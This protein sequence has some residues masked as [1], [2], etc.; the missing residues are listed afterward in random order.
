M[1]FVD[2]FGDM[3]QGLGRYA[4]TEQTGAT[5][6]GL[7]FNDSDFESFVCREECGCITTRSTT[8]DYDWNVHSMLAVQER[9]R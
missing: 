9:M 5:E 1:R 6:F 3:E 4:T 2:D 8:Q 7:G